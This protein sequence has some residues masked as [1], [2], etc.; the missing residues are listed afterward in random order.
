MSK[1]LL[2]SS[3]LKK[4]LLPKESLSRSAIARTLSIVPANKMH[5]TAAAS[6]ADFLSFVNASPTPFHAVKSVKAKLVAAGFKEI[7]VG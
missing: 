7:K 5:T 1:V 6:A 2:L 3:F 4:P